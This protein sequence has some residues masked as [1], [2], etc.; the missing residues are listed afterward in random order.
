[1]AEEHARGRLGTKGK[2][3]GINYIGGRGDLKK[4]G[5]PK[6]KHRRHEEI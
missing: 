5:N 2:H 6:R 3:A 4:R 1:M